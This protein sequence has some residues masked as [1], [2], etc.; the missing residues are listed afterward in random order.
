MSTIPKGAARAVAD[1]SSG[2]ILGSVEIAA[3]PERVFA[4]VSSAEVAQW[5]GAPGVYQVTKWTGDLRPG[6]AWQS[7]GVGA[8][9]KAFSVSGHF[10]EIA[11]PRLLVQ[12]WKHDWEVDAPVTT[13][14]YLID[15]IPS[16]SRVTI[17]HEGFGDRAASCEAHATGW[18]QVM[19]W[20]QVHFRGAA[21]S[22]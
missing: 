21:P 5:W 19:G 11:P 1:L 15:P 7:H 22:A 6:G 14:R 3:P 18:E 2:V 20:L 16:G 13:I 17:R 10:V 12:T 4:A 8:D 9:G